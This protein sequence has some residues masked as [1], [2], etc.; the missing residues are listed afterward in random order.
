MRTDC[1]RRWSDIKAMRNEE[2]C[3][4]LRN[5]FTKRFEK[6]YGNSVKKL[7][8]DWERMVTFLFFSKETLGSFTNY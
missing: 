7:H 2:E 6:N 4:R 1:S 3:E 5:Q 8:N